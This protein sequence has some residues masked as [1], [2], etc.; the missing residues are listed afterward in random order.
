MSTSDARMSAQSILRV[1]PPVLPVALPKPSPVGTD[2]EWGDGEWEMVRRFTDA[3]GQV[4]VV[5]MRRERDRLEKKLGPRIK[6]IENLEAMQRT[7]KRF[8]KILEAYTLGEHD[9]PLPLLHM[10]SRLRP[11]YFVHMD[12][13]E[14]QE[15]APIERFKQAHWFDF[16]RL[17]TARA[18]EMIAFGKELTEAGLVRL[19]FDVC[20][21]VFPYVCPDGSK[22]ASACLLRQDADKIVAEGV[23]HMEA[24]G[25]PLGLYGRDEPPNDP[26]FF[27]MA[28]LSSRAIVHR[29]HSVA[30]DVEV[31]GGYRG[32]SYVQ[33][34]LRDYARGA[35]DPR[36]HASPRL[37]W[38]RGHIRRLGN[39]TTWVRA[40]LV[41]KSENG[42]IVHDY[43]R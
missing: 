4:D 11:E 18:D 41:G 6:E 10:R 9:K 29:R 20:V 40:S 13:K 38:R 19:P 39:R 32:D 12:K 16:R 43:V 34:V 33:V 35:G 3:N 17:P 24:Q 42:V 28:V 23:I 21:F 1:A 26:I 30:S 2:Q 8:V 31:D 27:A 15:P 36:G 14:Q 22:V 25:R 5:G 7:L 37:H